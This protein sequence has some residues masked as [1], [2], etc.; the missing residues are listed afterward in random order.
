M[1]KVPSNWYEHFFH[2]LAL[3]LWRKAI[4]PK[5]TKSEADFLVKVLRCAKDAHL[6]DVPCGNG[7]LSLA[8]AARG[9]RL[10]GMDISKEFVDEARAAASAL[11]SIQ[12]EPPEAAGNANEV[13]RA[14]G[15]RLT[16]GTPLPQL[17]SPG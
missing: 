7:R 6:L 15:L 5:Q 2:G 16:G 10:T 9:Y 4:S 12:P 8:L 13:A 1:N 14:S 11:N 17:L 3:D